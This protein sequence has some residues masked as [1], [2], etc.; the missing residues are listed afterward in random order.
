MNMKKLLLTLTLPIILFLFTTCNT[1][2]T[3]MYGD[4]MFWTDININ[5]NH[6]AI[7]V[8]F[9]SVTRRITRSYR[10]KPACGSE[11]CVTFEQVPI[12]TYSYYAT[13]NLGYWEGEVTVYYN[14]CSTMKLVSSFKGI[15]EED[16]PDSSYR[17]DFP[18]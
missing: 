12:G 11:G 14:K 16:L 9:R 6:S 4:I 13:D 5:S 15:T 18:K 7:S 2:P 8:T 10:V 17:I 1:D 3:K